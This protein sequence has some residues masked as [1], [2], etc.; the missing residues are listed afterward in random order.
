LG[1]ILT[2][3]ELSN[4]FEGS[5]GSIENWLEPKIEPSL[6][7]LP[8][9]QKSVKRS[10]QKISK[11]ALISLL[12]YSLN[13]GNTK[14]YSNTVTIRFNATDFYLYGHRFGYWLN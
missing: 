14:Q 6:F 9:S 7:S 12:E 2:T 13:L 11:S 8:K 10:V 5:W 3:F 4:N 1:L